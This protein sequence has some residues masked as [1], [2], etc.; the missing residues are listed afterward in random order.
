[1]KLVV[2]GPNAIGAAVE[3]GLPIHR[4]WATQSKNIPEAFQKLPF[5]RASLSD[6]DGILRHKNHQGLAAEVSIKLPTWHEVVDAAIANGQPLVIAENIEDPH[7]LGAMVRAAVGL[8]AAGLL[9]AKRRAASLTDAVVRS[10]A[11]VALRY[12]PVTCSGSIPALVQQL[13]RQMIPTIGLSLQGEDFRVVRQRLDGQHL[14]ALVIG[15]EARGLTRLTAERCQELAKID[16]HTDVESL[17]A[18]VACAVSL[19]LLTQI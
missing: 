17:N 11:G 13:N 4:C 3:F 5:K 8:G 6:L 9:V 7:N 18:S 14:F 1:M 19:A 10:S 16:L 15:N 2:S 12:P